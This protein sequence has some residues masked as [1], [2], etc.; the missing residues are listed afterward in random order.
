MY[1]VCNI[2]LIIIV[3]LFLINV[4]IRAATSSN[5]KTNALS[6]EDMIACQRAI[7]E[8]YYRHRI[9]PKENTTPKPS[10]QEVVTEEVLRGKVEDYLHKTNALQKF[11]NKV[12]T[13]AEMQAEIDRM[14]RDTKNPLMLNELWEALH[15]DPLRIAE[16]LARPILVSRLL[17]DLYHHDHRFQ[18]EIKKRAEQL[19][20]QYKTIEELRRAEG[21]Y[22]EAIYVKTQTALQKNDYRKTTADLSEDYWHQLLLQLSDAFNIHTDS[23]EAEALIGA[24]PEGVLS[25]L[26]EDSEKFYVWKILSKTNEKINIATISWYKKSFEE[27]WNSIKETFADAIQHSK[28]SYILP[29]IKLDTCINDTWTPTSTNGAPAGRIEHTAVWTGSE[30]IVGGGIT[31]SGYEHTMGRY[32]LATD[33]WITQSHIAM[34]AKHTAVWSGSEVIYYSG[35]MV[36][37]YPYASCSFMYAQWLCNNPYGYWSDASRYNPATDTWSYF[38]ASSRSHH[39]AVWTGNEMIVWGG[40][41]SDVYNCFCFEHCCIMCTGCEPTPTTRYYT[42][43]NGIRYNPATNNVTSITSPLASMEGSIIWTGQEAIVWGGRQY[44]KNCSCP[45]P[46]IYPPYACGHICQCSESSSTDDIGYRYNPNIGAWTQLSTV[47]APAGQYGHSAVWTGT[48]MIIWPGAKKY[49]PVNDTWTPISTNGAPSNGPSVWTGAEMLTWG[50]GTNQGGRYNP[51]SDTWTPVST[52]NAPSARAIN[53][54]IWT[55]EK[56]IVWGGAPY[57]NTGGIYCACGD[58]VT[59]FFMGI[60]SIVDINQCAITGI[61][62]SWHQP[63]SWGQ[64]AA[65]GTYELRRYDGPGC[66]GTHTTLASNLPA[67]T[68]SYIDTATTGGTIYYYQVIATNN[69]SPPASSSGFNSC[70]PGQDYSNG[71]APSGLTNNSA[72]DINGCTDAGVRITWYKDAS[73]WGDYNNGTRTYEVLRDGIAIV[74]N[75]S[76]GTTVYVD[77][78]GSNNVTYTYTV[79]YINGCGLSSAPTGTAAADSVGNSPSGLINNSAIDVDNCA[80]TGVRITW[81]ADPADWGDGSTGTRTYQVLRN[82]NSITALSYGATSYIDMGGSNGVSYTYSV[83]YINGCGISTTT[84]PGAHAADNIGS[85]PSGLTNNS[86]SDLNSCADTGVRIT[87]TQDPANWG[88]SGSGTRTCAVL[89]DGTIIATNIPYGTTTFIDTAGTNE[90]VYTYTVRY[91]NSCGLSTITNPGDQAADNISALASLKPAIN[92]SSS[93]THNG[94]IETDEAVELIGNVQNNCASMATNVLGTLNTTD[95]IIITNHHAIYPDINPNTSQTC[96]TCYS[97]TAPTANRPQTHWD[98]IVTES[99]T[100]S[101]CSPVSYDFSYHVGNSFSD[102]PPSQ[103]FYSYIE[104]IL[105][106]G[107]TSGCTTG[108][109]C[110]SA[111][112]QRQHMAKFICASMKAVTSGSCTVSSCSGI[113]A[114]V[115]ASNLFCGFIEGLY[116]A[117]VVSGC[118]SMPQLLYCPDSNTQRQAMAKFVCNGMNNTAPGSCTITGCAGIFTDVPSSNPFCGYIEGLYNAA[119]ISGCGSGIYCPYGYVSR[120]QMA[121]FLV[122]AFGFSL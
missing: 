49:D 103:L 58:T 6:M 104:K 19:L 66:S 46:C 100:C 59:P 85:S 7:D 87:W 24:L 39:S 80:D 79:R 30:M 51:Y 50:G 118:Q 62:I 95:P 76:Y 91:T 29:S 96:T 113:F 12:I 82:N 52:T 33:S 68:T 106:A 13:P 28:F 32:N 121:K 70:A 48:D 90:Q 122:N 42:L 69:A 34:T 63:C 4:T 35:Y 38:S 84:S 112:V 114:D 21:T 78:A 27:W 17:W 108:T 98:F 18:D 57:T 45:D 81:D 64:D 107:V 5:I 111:L 8:V 20:Q 3:L 25:P 75:I 94:I 26:Q 23:M 77:T 116:N 36:P 54:I 47:N 115:P 44:S 56:M 16:C 99:P 10:F 117:G 60:D 93:P 55:G 72:A 86:A 102:V 65:T 1:R 73:S 15:N 40:R 2:I 31:S 97:L 11:W 41:L 53:T 109:Y 67:E 110:P 101:G 89:R 119:V 74:S 14:A 61:Q 22:F 71:S 9:W 83:R 120:D 37:N 43:S 92:D 88:D 105:H